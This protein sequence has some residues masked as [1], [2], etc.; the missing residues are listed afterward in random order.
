MRLCNLFMYLNNE[1]RVNK[2]WKHN[3]C[4]VEDGEQEQQQK[5]I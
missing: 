4:Y 3:M 2:R 5:K 1:N